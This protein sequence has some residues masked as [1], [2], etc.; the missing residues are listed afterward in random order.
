M[1]SNNTN[2]LPR[3]GGNVWSA[4]SRGKFCQNCQRQTCL[5]FL[6]I[7]GSR[8]GFDRSDSNDN[9]GRGR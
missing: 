4:G 9:N 2:S 7:Q 3:E 6:F 1:S 5:S 8:G